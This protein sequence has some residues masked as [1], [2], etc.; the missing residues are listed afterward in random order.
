MKFGKFDGITQMQ[1][2]FIMG[3]VFLFLFAFIAIPFYNSCKQKQTITKLKSIYSQ[4]TSANRTYTLATS[5]DIGVFDV[6]LP[7]DEFAQKYFKPYMPV[8][9]VCE[10]SQAKCW[11]PV[12]YTDLAKN[13]ISGKA[14]YS[15]ALKDGSVIGFY[16]DN[17]GLISIIADIDGKAG[18]NKLGKDVFIFSFFNEDRLPEICDSETYTS[19][20]GLKNGIHF[21]GYDKCGIP[22]DMYSS[23]EL[24]GTSLE[25]S[26]NKKALKRTNGTGIG[27]ACLALISSLNWTID[28]KYPW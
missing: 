8:R 7:A 21:G 16:K 27:S 9:T 11:N 3:I 10:E 6:D 26:C 2:L 24:S 17:D 13:K 22:H 1:T 23:Y 14:T 25:D 18:E 12:Q 4:L 5:D 28:K 20:A 19:K 15:L